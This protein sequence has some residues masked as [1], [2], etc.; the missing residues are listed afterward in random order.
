MNLGNLHLGA[1]EYR[2]AI[3]RYGLA[4]AADPSL[5]QAYYYMAVSHLQ[6]DETSEA[7]DALRHALEFSPD[8]EAARE[9]LVGLGVERP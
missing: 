8:H 9:L 6:V 2:A 1:G 5:S 3:E 7:I 4:V